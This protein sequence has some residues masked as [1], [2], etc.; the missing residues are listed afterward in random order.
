MPDDIHAHLAPTAI[1]MHKHIQIRA[2]TKKHY[3]SPTPNKDNSSL[4]ATTHSMTTCLGLGPHRFTSLHNKWYQ[5]QPF[6][7]TFTLY[8][9]FG[10][11]TLHGVERVHQVIQTTHF[12]WTRER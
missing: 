3:L 2:R 6:G 9:I 4:F 11:S 5:M 10:I 12:A 7:I 8:R 1:A